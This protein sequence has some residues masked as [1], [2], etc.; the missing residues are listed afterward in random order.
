MIHPFRRV[1]P[2]TDGA[3]DGTTESRA[4]RPLLLGV[5]AHSLQV[6]L[7]ILFLYLGIPKLLGRDEAARLAA[8][9]VDRYLR[10][11]IGW[12]ELTVAGLLWARASG[13]LFHSLVAGLALI[14]VGL[15]HRAPLAAV[16]CLAA[17]GLSTWAR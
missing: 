1:Q 3:T 8:M 12:L 15:L 9:G 14:E 13:Y 6:G 4:S 10:D 2:A 7:G 5:V 17:H 11:T 16:A